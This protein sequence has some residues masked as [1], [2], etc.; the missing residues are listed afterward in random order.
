M[1]ELEVG[2]PSFLGFAR[3]RSRVKREH[4]SLQLSGYRNGSTRVYTYVRYTRHCTL[5]YARRQ[6]L[7]CARTD[8]DYQRYG[9]LHQ[10]WRMARPMAITLANKPRGEHTVKASHGRRG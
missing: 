5:S 9:P 4:E 7:R 6:K 1:Y 8:C 3:A 10:V 2:T